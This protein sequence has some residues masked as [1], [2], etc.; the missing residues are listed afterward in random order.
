MPLKSCEQGITRSCTVSYACACMCV[1]TR[2]RTQLSWSSI[3]ILLACEG[4]N[5]RTG[6][7]AICSTDEAVAAEG[8][9]NEMAS[10]E[11]LW[12]LGRLGDAPEPCGEWGCW[13]EAL[14]LAFGAV[15]PE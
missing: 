3:I 9:W 15:D 14:W 4:D 6:S 10:K 2:N 8:S 13:E 12:A 11:Y 7:G 1:H 5:C